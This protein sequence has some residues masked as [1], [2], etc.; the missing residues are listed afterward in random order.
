MHKYNVYNQI[1]FREDCTESSTPQSCWVDIKILLMNDTCAHYSMYAIG[2]LSGLTNAYKFITHN[3]EMYTC[4]WQTERRADRLIDCRIFALK[5]SKG[6]GTPATSYVHVH[7][8]MY[9]CK[10]ETAML[11]QCT[12]T[13]SIIKCYCSFELKCHMLPPSSYP[14]I[15]HNDSNNIVFE[16]SP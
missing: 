14:P 1:R 16:I 4:R 6:R 12:I 5:H 13:Q 15:C 7:K 11:S 9:M 10:H 8:S 3:S 2:L